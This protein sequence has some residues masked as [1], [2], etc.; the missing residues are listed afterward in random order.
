MMHQDV[1]IFY[2]TSILI[3]QSA[4]SNTNLSAKS[5]IFLILLTILIDNC[6]QFAP[7]CNSSSII[8]LTSIEDL[9]RHSRKWQKP[10]WVWKDQFRKWKWVLYWSYY[11]SMPHSRCLKWLIG[12]VMETFW[13]QSRGFSMSKKVECKMATNFVNYLIET[14][15]PIHGIMN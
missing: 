5:F 11:G 13:Y 2:Q 9:L 7:R 10:G 15:R 12:I 6:W 1:A 8:L 14:W 4:L 3:F